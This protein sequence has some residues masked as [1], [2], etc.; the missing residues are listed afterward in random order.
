MATRLRPAMQ[1]DRRCAFLASSRK[2]SSL[3]KFCFSSCRIH[4]PDHAAQV[5]PALSVSQPCPEGDAWG[6]SV[7]R[8]LVLVEGRSCVSWECNLIRLGGLQS[9]RRSCR[10]AKGHSPK[11]KAVGEPQGGRSGQDGEGGE[12]GSHCSLQAH[13]LDLDCNLAAI[14]QPGLV[15]LG[16]MRPSSEMQVPT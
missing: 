14:Q 11:V 12:V 5:L 16:M 13:I 8:P 1:S 7:C 2:S 6:K 4:L 9:F 15:H 3:A 10:P